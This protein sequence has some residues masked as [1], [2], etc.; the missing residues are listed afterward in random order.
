M[1]IFLS[2]I[3]SHIP[4]PEKI[5]LNCLA[6]LTA[7]GISCLSVGLIG[8][9]LR[10]LIECTQWTLNES[11]ARYVLKSPRDGARRKTSPGVDKKKKSGTRKLILGHR[12][13]HSPPGV[14]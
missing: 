4:S 1:N 3:I 8:K 13:W 9:N 10:T 11:I 14:S 7:V 2:D 6:I 12:V 5:H